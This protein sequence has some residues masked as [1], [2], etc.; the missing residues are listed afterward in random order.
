MKLRDLRNFSLGCAS[1]LLAA[2]CVVEGE[3]AFAEDW[4]GIASLQFA[5][6]RD[7]MH[8]CGGTMI[9]EQW[10]LTAAHCVDEAR[11]ERNGKAAQFRRDEQGM[12]RRLG[13]M[14]VAIGRTHLAD[15]MDVKTYAVTGIHLHP[16]YVPGHYERGSDIALIRVESGYKGP[17]MRVDGLGYDPLDLPEDAYADIAGYGNTSEVDESDG[18]LNSRGRAVFAPSL[19]L[20]QAQMPLMETASCKAALDSMIERHDLESIYGDY[21]VGPATLC[22]GGGRQDSCYGDSGGPLV[23]RDATGEVVQVGLVSWGLGCGRDGSPG[24]Y[25]RAAHFSDWIA[26]TTA[27]EGSS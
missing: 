7:T 11:I 16:D 2:A 4:P 23:Y 15:D 26:T 14:R 13:P 18:A 20:Q 24:V 21:E 25:T 17:Y 27:F 1:L 5:Q 22:A 9:A 8:E 12:V 3:D 19:R 6:G 10:M